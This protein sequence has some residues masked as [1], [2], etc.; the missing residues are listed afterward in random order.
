MDARR[1]LPPGVRPTAIVM[2]VGTIMSILDATIVNV[3]LNG[4]SAAL[5]V[6]LAS[7][8]WVVTGYLLALGAVIPLCAFLVRRYG[9]SIV[10]LASLA[11]FTAGSG[12]CALASSEGQL[13]AFRAIQGI[14][15]GLVLPA[16]LSMLAKAVS[17]R[18]LPQVMSIVGVPMVL[19]PVFGPTLGGFLLLTVGWRSIFLINVPIGIV[20]V[21]GGLRWL[22][23]DRPPPAAR[24]GLG[25]LDL[26]GFVLAAAGAVGVTYGL[27]ESVSAAALLAPAVLLPSI[28]G[29]LLIAVFVLRSLGRRAPLLDFRLYLHRAYSAASAAT[30]AQ[31]AALFGSMILLPL[32]FELARGEDAIHTG[33][34]L[35]PRGVGAAL[36]M[37]LSGRATAR[38]GAGLT[39][40]CGGVIMTAAM[41]PF[42]FPA[43]LDSLAWSEP[44]MVAGGIGI[45]LATMPAMTAAMSVLSARQI[46]DAS[47]QLN[48][49]QR[50]GASL[51]TAAVVIALQNALR[52]ARTHP[53]G[54]DVATAASSAFAHTFIWVVLISLGSLLPTVVLWRLERRRPAEVAEVLVPESW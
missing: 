43:L 41:L 33:L 46:D 48:V 15:G 37:N 35:I 4:L 24:P 45:G 27:A 52:T 29:M 54:P 20:T 36:G 11:L 50:V 3:A 53:S 16:G 31:G 7:V 51:G 2:V 10:Y 17:R 12:L 34:L 1:R 30:F 5:H 14:G 21:A 18:E 49:I 32:F 13:V 19:A 44:L 22:P 39:S 42:C 47:P 23:S 28:G 8:Q 6:S 9:G 38:I 26:P 40:L 25:D